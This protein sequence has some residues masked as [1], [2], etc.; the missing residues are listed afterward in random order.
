MIKNSGSGTLE[1]TLSPAWV[2]RA[3]RCPIKS[4]IRFGKDNPLLS[5]ECIVKT[6][7]H[8]FRAAPYSSLQRGMPDARAS[9]RSRN[10][11]LGLLQLQQILPT[12]DLEVM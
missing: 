12:F 8:I 7:L 6:K 11:A 5:V 3:H 4:V 2:S 9:L 10:G 1:G